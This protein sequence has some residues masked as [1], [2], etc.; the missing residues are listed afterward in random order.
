MNASANLA[1]DFICFVEQ[2]GDIDQFFFFLLCPPLLAWACLA[3][4]FE[5]PGG[6]MTSVS[7][8]R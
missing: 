2:E 5:A 3:V 4:C 6:G 1:Y 8:P 7:P